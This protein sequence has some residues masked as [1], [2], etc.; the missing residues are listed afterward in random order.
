MPIIDMESRIGHRWCINCS[1]DIAPSALSP[2]A[3]VA[4]CRTIGET[5]SHTFSFHSKSSILPC[6]TA[7]IV[8]PRL[9]SCMKSAVITP[10]VAESMVWRLSTSQRKMEANKSICSWSVRHLFRRCTAS[11]PTAFLA[12]FLFLA[13]SGSSSLYDAYSWKC[14]SLMAIPPVFASLM[15]CLSAK[16]I[17]LRWL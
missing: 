1:S 16:M 7:S 6:F 9:P 15:A 5:K 4:S 11:S 10:S 3:A 2:F 12:S 17:S 14:P 13:I 8:I